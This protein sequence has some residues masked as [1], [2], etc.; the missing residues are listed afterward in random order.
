MHVKTPE[1]FE[2]EKL[3]KELAAT[4][5]ALRAMYDLRGGM[6]KPQE[7]RPTF[8]ALRL[9]EFVLNGYS[10]LKWES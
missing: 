7:H 2:I 3:T 10:Y 6:E 1:Q 9:T 8:E 4:K 5:I